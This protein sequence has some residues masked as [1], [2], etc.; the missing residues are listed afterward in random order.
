MWTAETLASFPPPAGSGLY[1]VVRL[2]RIK[3]IR[4]SPYLCDASGRQ[5]RLPAYANLLGTVLH[6]GP[7]ALDENREPF[8]P[9]KASTPEYFQLQMVIDAHP[10][11]LPYEK[12]R[13]LFRRDGELARNFTHGYVVVRPKGMKP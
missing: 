13:E 5:I 3:P 7:A 8:N 1:E 4:S 9:L 10:D 11:G 2:I 12:H 6:V